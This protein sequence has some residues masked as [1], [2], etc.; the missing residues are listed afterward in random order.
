[1]GATWRAVGP[2]LLLALFGLHCGPLDDDEVSGDLG[3]GAFAYGCVD[4][5]DPACRDGFDADEFPNGVSTGSRFEVSFT[6]FDRVFDDP[7][8]AR[9]FPA[10]PAF[11]AE[12][13]TT[14]RAR[15][16][17]LA[18]L[19][20][21]QLN[22]GRVIDFVHVRI[23]DIV[24]LRVVESDGDPVSLTLTEG[25]LLELRVFGVDDVGT[26][27]SGSR[28]YDW[29]TSDS[30]VVALDTLSPTALMT[31]RAEAAGPATVTVET[32]GATASVDF[33][34]VAP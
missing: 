9:V 21:Q 19:L 33:S 27:L 34:V 31:V 28:S 3:Q 17:G 32:E 1:M 11:I 18:A 4:S 6:E 7:D 14:F 2:G 12:E 22:G 23:A 10:A 25:E 15:S 24:E 8:A 20:A 13:G 5:S 29:S 16:A 30:L 26:M